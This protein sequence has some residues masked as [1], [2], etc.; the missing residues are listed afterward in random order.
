ME[1][2]LSQKRDKMTPL[3]LSPANVAGPGW[4]RRALVGPLVGQP[5]PNSVSVLQVGGGVPFNF[6]ERPI[7]QVKSWEA[8]KFK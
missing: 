5:V 2:S 8:A 1:T 6:S 3:V 4:L 7:Y